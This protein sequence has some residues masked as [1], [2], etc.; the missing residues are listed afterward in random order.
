MKSDPQTPPIYVGYVVKRYPRFSETFVVNEILAHERAGAKVAIFALGPVDEPHFQYDIAQV[1]AP[2]TRLSDKQRN[3]ESFWALLQQA[4]QQL[5]D[6]ANNL[7]LAQHHSVHEFA[8]AVMLALAVRAQGIQC[9]HAH[10]A[11]RAT[12]V[13]WLPAR[14]SG[15]SYTFTAHAKDIYYPYEEATEM[16]RKLR[17]SAQAITVSDYNLAYLKQQYGRDADK[18][19]RVYNGIDLAKF[20]YQAPV[21]RTR[22]ILAVGRLVAK[23]GFDILIEALNLLHSRGVEF[24]ATIVGY[25]PLQDTLAAQIQTAGIAHQV[26]LA[27]PLPQPGIIDAMQNAAMVVAPCVVSEEGDRDGLPT[28]LLEAMALGTPVI[29]T[30]VAGIPELVTE[31]E[32]GLCV[33]PQDPHVLANAMLRLL[34]E[35]PTGLALSLRARERI[36]QHYDI[37]KNTTQLR[38]IFRANARPISAPQ[39]GQS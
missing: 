31:G 2:V 11:T 32:T 33:A 28:I 6:F 25:G 27:G 24:R 29:S 20:P 34:D 26:T 15:V 39:G 13:T 22:H 17:D 12:T 18:A 5:P 1:R 36:E 3:C 7:F 10:F 21:N 4:H 30:R 23:K 14:L 37:D 19:I 16:A 38:A 35:A 8:Q 9:L